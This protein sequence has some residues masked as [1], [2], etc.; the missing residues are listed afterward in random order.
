[1]RRTVV[2]RPSTALALALGAGA[3]VALSVSAAFMPV[4]SQ[5]TAPIGGGWSTLA[6]IVFFTVL[7]LAASAVTADSPSGFILVATTAPVCAASALGGPVAGA[8]V[9]LIGSTERR[10]LSRGFPWYG[11]VGNHTVLILAATAGGIAASIVRARASSWIGDQTVGTVLSVV[12]SGVLFI[13]VADVGTGLQVAVR[14]RRPLVSLIRPVIASQLPEHG[15]DVA[16]AVLMAVVYTSGAWWLTPV[17]LVPILSVVIG[18]RRHKVAWQADHDPLTGTVLRRELDRQLATILAAA[19][20][21][22]RAAGILV[23]DVDRFI[24]INDAFGHEVGDRVLREVAARLSAGVRPADTVARTGGDEFVILLPGIG[25]EPTLLARGEA[26]AA[27]VAAPM[28]IS[29][30]QLN[31]GLSIGGVLVPR[32]APLPS[33]L[34]SVADA[35]MYEAKRS[36]GGCRLGSSPRS[37]HGFGQ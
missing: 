14:Q 26:L 31:V 16:M 17:F 27:A 6:G 36:G 2:D 3:L 8:L 28:E 30:R 29:G 13:L 7:A 19:A 15:A 4:G 22:A 24:G 12:A 5:I 9:A 33:D 35:A 23:I 21:A 37:A 34:R 32:D 20:R 10:E 25:D 1:M 18:A 11:L